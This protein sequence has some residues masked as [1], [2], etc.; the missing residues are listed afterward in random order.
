MLEGFDWEG[1][2]SLGREIVSSR[3]VEVRAELLS[4]R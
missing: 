2:F 4:E 3:E 1:I